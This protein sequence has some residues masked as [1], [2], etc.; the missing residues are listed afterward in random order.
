MKIFMFINSFIKN[1]VKVGK[2]TKSTTTTKAI[3]LTSA[4]TSS[5]NTVKRS[6]YHCCS[7]DK[8]ST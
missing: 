4:L 1:W 7:Q 8:E 2:P 5:A 6:L 3:A